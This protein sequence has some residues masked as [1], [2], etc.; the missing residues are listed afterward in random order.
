MR[1]QTAG[2]FRDCKDQSKTTEA[3]RFEHGWFPSKKWNLCLAVRL[4]IQIEAQ[5]ISLVFETFLWK[6]LRRKRNICQQ[7]PTEVG[8]SK[9]SRLMW[10][11]YNSKRNKTCLIY[12]KLLISLVRMVLFCL[13]T[14]EKQWCAS[15]THVMIHGA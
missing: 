14:C 7:H 3:C 8:I 12:F 4:W 2:S 1:K 9:Y 6:V 15:G 5:C 13:R 10:T 11:N